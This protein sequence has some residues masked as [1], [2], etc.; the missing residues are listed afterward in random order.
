M[1]KNNQDIFDTP[2]PP[3]AE[4]DVKRPRAEAVAQRHS[5]KEQF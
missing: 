1:I 4:T 5:A 3:Q 2:N